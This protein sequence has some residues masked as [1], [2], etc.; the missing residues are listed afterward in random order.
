MVS[1]IKEIIAKYINSNEIALGSTQAKMCVQIINRIF[2]KMSAG[3][4]FSA[5]KVDNNF[6]CDG[7][8][9]YI[10]SLLSNYPLERNAGIIAPSTERVPWDLVDFEEEWEYA[11]DIKKF[12]Q[13][14]A[15][16]NN[17]TLEEIEEMVK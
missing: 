7:H 16:N 3:I 2:K 6:I 11:E 17:I 5:I 13:Q 10:A 12:N 15:E 8:H 4:K 9:R 14:D 1:I